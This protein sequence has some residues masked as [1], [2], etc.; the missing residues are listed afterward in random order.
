VLV[1]AC[2]SFIHQPSSEPAAPQWSGNSD[3]ADPQNRAEMVRHWLQS[4]A[5]F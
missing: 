4:G 5:T 1:A 2:E 3:S